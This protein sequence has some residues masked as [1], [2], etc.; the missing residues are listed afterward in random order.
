[1]RVT[2]APGLIAELFVHVPEVEVPVTVQL[3]PP[4]PLTV[5]LPVLPAALTVTVVALK[6]AV[7]D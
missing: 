4:V 6:A 1:V 3:M 7:T 5:P 2:V